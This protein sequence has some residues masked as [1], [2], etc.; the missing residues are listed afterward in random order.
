MVALHDVRSNLHRRQLVR[1]SVLLAPLAAGGVDAPSRGALGSSG[2]DHPPHLLVEGAE[3]GFGLDM[4]NEF[5]RFAGMSPAAYFERSPGQR[6][7]F[8]GNF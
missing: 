6:D 3:D 4:I 7:L 5:R 2:V 1:R 8:V